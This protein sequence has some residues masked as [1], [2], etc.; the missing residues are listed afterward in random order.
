MKKGRKW[1]ETRHLAI[2][3]L[4]QDPEGDEENQHA[5]PLPG[6]VEK[7]NMGYVP[8]IGMVLVHDRL[9]FLAGTGWHAWA[10]RGWPAFRRSQAEGTSEEGKYGHKIL[11]QLGDDPEK[12]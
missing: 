11:A 12:G 1:R 7:L 6:E 5:F 4:P 8:G 2:G 3:Q 9:Q 10:G